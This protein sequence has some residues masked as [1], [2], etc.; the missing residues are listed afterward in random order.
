M[1]AP[2]F[3]DAQLRAQHGLGLDSFAYDLASRVLVCLSDQLALTRGGPVCRS[4]VY[5]GEEIAPMDVCC[6]GTSCHGMAAVRVYRIAPRTGRFPQQDHT[7]RLHSCDKLNYQVTLELTVY[8]CAAT[9][10]DRG[11]PPS[12]AD[13]TWNV[14]VQMDDA[15]A[16]RRAV[17][18][19]YSAIAGRQVAGVTLPY[20]LT[21]D[22]V[23]DDYNPVGPAGDC[24]GG[25]QRFIF[26]V[27]D[28]PCDTP[29]VPVVA[30]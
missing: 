9:L 23:E 24:L 28:V 5:P 2:G 17:G 8:R 19:C 11:D 30:V 6:E 15:A 26:P 12:V 13:L 29:P 21:G 10:D 1:T 22:Y 25:R 14:K 20:T 18:C 3:S 7:A 4:S 16:M 27:T